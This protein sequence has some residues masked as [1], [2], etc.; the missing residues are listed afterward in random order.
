MTIVVHLGWK[1]V[2]VYW[3]MS[4]VNFLLGGKKNHIPTVASCLLG[5]H[6]SL[7]GSDVL[8]YGELVGASVFTGAYLVI[9][10]YQLEEV[11]VS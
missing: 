9:D 1:K 6:V 2:S 10:R 7:K 8:R 3:S 5:H 4:L 11:L